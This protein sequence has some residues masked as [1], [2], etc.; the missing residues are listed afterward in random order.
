MQLKR[1][2]IKDYKILK[3]FILEFPND[4]KK[5]ISVFIG[6]NGSGKS[7]IL[8]A[9]AEIFNCVFLFKQSKFDFE[10]E[11]SIKSD[12][13]LSEFSISNPKL[14]HIPIKITGYVGYLPKTEINFS[15]LSQEILEHADTDIKLSFAQRNFRNLIPDNIVIYYSGLSLIM[16]EL[17]KPHENIL[18]ESYRKGNANIDRNFFYYK[19][20]HFGIILLSLLSYE[21][22][23]IPEFLK[24]KAKIEDIESIQILLKK[25]GW[26]KDSIENFWGAE[27]EVRKFLDFLKEQSQTNKNIGIKTGK[28]EK[29]T[30]LLKGKGTL[31]KIREF[32]IEEKKLFEILNIMLVDDLL[33]EIYF[34]LIKMENG[35]QQVFNILSEGEQQ[36]ITIK[37]LTEFLSGKNTLFLFDE[38]DTYLHPEWQRQFIPEIQTSVDNTPN[39][40]N[41]YL[42]AT[43][44][45]NIISGIEKDSLFVLEQGAVKEIPFNSFGKN[46]ESLLIDFFNVEVVRNKYVENLLVEVQGMVK[47]NQFDSSEFKSKFQELKDILR[48]T[49]PEI[50]NINL[51]IAKSRKK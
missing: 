4:S 39:F 14:K 3:E 48:P 32:L 49:S 42:V 2:Y 47:N 46:V 50:V 9:V 45:P 7:T 36:A 30:F 19:P 33:D 11:Y 22:G 40:E 24:S 8:E 37:G 28:R 21:Y 38:P 35:K 51:E 15:L 25:P 34:S 29:I 1:L 43:H 10:I 20:E 6:A 31:Y 5:Y 17:C 27:G 41:Y 13:I 26:H 23:D 12:D 18:S 16:E 44:S